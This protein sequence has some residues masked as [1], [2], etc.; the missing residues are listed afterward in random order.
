MATAAQ[1]IAQRLKEAGCTHVYGIPG[2]EVLVLMEALREV[3]IDFILTKHENNAGFMA[4]GAW[5]A[6][7]RPPVL[8][9]TIGP[10]MANA[11]NV[12]A[13]AKL[14]RV[15]LIF[16]TGSV[17]PW[18]RHTYTHQVIDHGAIVRPLVK[19]SFEV[20]PGAAD[21]IIDKAMS[22]ATDSPPGPV[23]IDLPMVAG[24][25]L[26]PDASPVR[27]PRAH[28]EVGPGRRASMCSRTHFGSHHSTG[29]T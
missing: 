23:H 1:L 11:V 29:S 10:G 9:T 18:E 25:A 16:I 7:G 8:L 5:H 27:R 6:T 14:D 28:S 17:D 22:I 2:G 21:A 26:E 12:V 15:P 24:A 20:V 4:E 13:N 19:A 3:G